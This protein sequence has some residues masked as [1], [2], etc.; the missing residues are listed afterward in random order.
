[1]E[2]I[3]TRTELPRRVLDGTQGIQLIGPVARERPDLREHVDHVSKSLGQLLAPGRNRIVLVSL[4]VSPEL[5][6]LT[7]GAWQAGAIVAF[8]GVSATE[9]EVNDKIA[10][11]SPSAVITRP[12]DQ[13]FDQHRRRGKHS[14]TTGAVLLLLDP[15][16]DHYVTKLSDHDAWLAFTSGSTGTPKPA[17]L[18]ATSILTNAYEVAHYLNLSRKDR[19]LIFTPPQF[20]YTIIQILSCLCGGATPLLWPN[21]LRSIASLKNFAFEHRATG[22][23]ANPSAFQ[24]LSSG[25]SKPLRSMRFVLSAG[26]PLTK[27]L[28]RQ[29]KQFFPSARILSGYGCTENVNRIC[30]ANVTDGSM[31][32]DHISAPVGYPIGGTSVQLAKN[33]SGEAE[34]VISGE[35]LMRGYLPEIVKST[36]QL[37]SFHTGDLGLMD[38]TLGLVI[39]GRTK[40]QINVANEMVSP[41][42]LEAVISITSGV[43][44]CA[45]AGVFDELLGEVPVALCVTN[46]LS[47]TELFDAVRR[48]CARQLSRTKWPKYVIRVDA[49][50]IPRTDYGK[51]DRVR[52]ES[53]VQSWPHKQ[54][55]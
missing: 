33:A 19:I 21:G 2:S 4:P 10:A 7:L 45:V 52:L 15:V 46:Y 25:S 54:H 31:W 40:N 12:T 17:V 23:S 3:V 28:L 49:K 27:T 22:V 30:F 16:D 36:D 20:T 24:I 55:Q 14:L 51:I 8:V 34:I 13:R 42:E 1:M 9:K 44:D 29:L 47:Q 53:L 37:A 26:Q 6:I 11:S 48:E 39:T 5:V 50:D 41:E 32:G 43:L 38:S 35:S 18:T